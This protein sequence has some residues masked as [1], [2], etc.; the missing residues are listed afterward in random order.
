M[1]PRRRRR[2][3]AE[4]LVAQRHELGD[5]SQEADG[6]VA[7]LEVVEVV[8]AHGRPRQVVLV[9]LEPGRDERGQPGHIDVGDHVGAAAHRHVAAGAARR[10]GVDR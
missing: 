6:A 1:A 7:D 4:Q 10:R 9:V 3:G 2:R 5:G 8:V